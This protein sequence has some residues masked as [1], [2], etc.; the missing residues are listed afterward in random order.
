MT[1]SELADKFN[2]TTGA[3]VV[4]RE[5]QTV[6]A[7]EH[8]RRRDADIEHCKRALEANV[9]P[10]LSE[11]KQH[12]GDGQFYFS[13]QIDLQDHKPVGVSFRI[14][15]GGVTTISTALGNI[16][17]TRSG[18]SGTERAWRTSILPMWSPSSPTR[19]ISRATRSPGWSRW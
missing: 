7:A 15:D 3:A 9:L 5:H 14:G 19:A 13:P 2:A 12:L 11:L 4:E 16:V 6:L 17:V 8:V 10:F 18:D 1:A